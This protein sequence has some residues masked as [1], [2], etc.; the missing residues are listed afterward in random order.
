V[1]IK[2]AQAQGL[3]IRVEAYPY[4][5]GST[6]LAASFFSDP[7]FEERNGLGY[8]SVQ[9]VTDGRRFRDREELLAAQKEEPS[10]LVLWHIL[11]TENNAH[12][13]D[14][15]DISVLYPNGA[16]ASDA[17]PWTLSDGKPYTGDDWP[18]P[19]DATSHPRSAGCFTR[20]IREWVRERRMVSLLEGIRKC[21]L[22]PAEILSESTPAMRAKGRLQA[23]ADADIVVFDFDELTD[24][25]TFSAMNRPAE[26]VRHL[27]VSG[28][29]L[30][31]DGVLDVA[32]RPGRPVR[33][34]VVAS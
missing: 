29:V 5:T 32:A 16:I 4:G 6:V 21:A 20:F 31:S 28:Q 22:I 25:A 10:T 33:R 30:I 27:V 19:K 8:D 23:G 2:K 11:D 1:L 18:L 12:H 9:R 24:R 26:G 7:K 34:P 17:M 3:P 13:R 14:L 15:L